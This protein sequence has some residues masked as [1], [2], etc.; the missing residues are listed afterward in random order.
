MKKKTDEIIREVDKLTKLEKDIRYR[1]MIVNKNFREHSEEEIK[2]VYEK[3]KELQLQ[4][5]I[6]KN[7][8]QILI[9]KRNE[10]ELRLKT[11]RETLKKAEKLMSQM[12]VILGYL[13]GDLR[14]IHLQLEDIKEKK[15]LGIKVIQAQEE[16]RYR[17][18]REIHDGPAQI[19]A[20]L[21]LKSELCEKL[22]DIDTEKAKKE[23]KALR[24][25]MRSSLQDVRK[26]IYDLRPMSLDDLGLIPTVERLIAQYNE[27]SDTFVEFKFF[28]EKVKLLPIVEVAIFRIIQ[29][30][31]NNI[32]KHS[33]AT[34][35]LVKI[36]FSDN[37]INLVIRDNGIGFSKESL[38]KAD[39]DRGYGLMSMEERVTLLNGKFEIN[40]SPG[41]GT[42][43]TATIP[44]DI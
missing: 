3:A 33:K 8:E 29:E 34:N 7:E 38:R 9:E 19:L 44:I 28:G 36:E 16:E 39:E 27:T 23:L 30:A 10:L 2:E 17:L 24:E 21:V 26:I 41:N 14:N 31:L 4:L 32:K 22:I 1:L 20:N 42:K 43:I 11:A 35:A 25:V 18:S 13:C 12:A 5:M 15:H 6:K 37:N 40:S